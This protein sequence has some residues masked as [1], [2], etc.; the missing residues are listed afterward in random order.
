MQGTRSSHSRRVSL[1]CGYW[2]MAP[3]DAS[4]KNQTLEIPI[5]RP[6]QGEIRLR[7][8]KRLDNELHLADES[9]FRPFTLLPRGSMAFR[10][11]SRD[12]SV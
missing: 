2:T 9:L 5:P 10:R 12:N 4:N 7:P 6:F 3:R 11:R 1:I 8:A